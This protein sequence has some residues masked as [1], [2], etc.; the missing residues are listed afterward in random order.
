MKRLSLLVASVF[1]NGCAVLHHIQVGDVASKKHGRQIPIDIKLSETG[2]DVEGGLRALDSSGS[3]GRKPGEQG[4][5]GGAAEIWAMLNMGPRTGMPVF[6]EKY[7]QNLI[8]EIYQK[9]P[10]GKITGLNSIREHRAYVYI[11]GEIV[12][13]TGFCI[14]DR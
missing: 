10:S 11:S 5:A 3:R 12:K 8:H 4:A 7:A 14:V 2:V 1:L 13:V 9:C 6:S